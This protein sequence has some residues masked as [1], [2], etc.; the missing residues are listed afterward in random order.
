MA[1]K[2]FLHILCFADKF[3]VHENVENKMSNTLK[4][5]H[6]IIAPTLFQDH[7]FPTILVTCPNI[8]F[9]KIHT[10]C[11]TKCSIWRGQELVL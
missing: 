2:V 6:D 3:F 7:F 8:V 4:F 9:I 10:S 5:K 1:N 11:I